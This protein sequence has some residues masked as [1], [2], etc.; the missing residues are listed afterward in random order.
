MCKETAAVTTTE[1][2][3]EKNDAALQKAAVIGAE[4]PAPPAADVIVGVPMAAPVGGEVGDLPVAKVVQMMPYEG[5]EGVR[6]VAAAAGPHAS[7]LVRSDGK[8]DR[9]HKKGEVECT[10]EPKE[11]TRFFSGIGWGVRNLLQ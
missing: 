3:P 7:Y 10:L 5:G 11:G 6:Y 8:I 2:E 9:T 1:M 4:A